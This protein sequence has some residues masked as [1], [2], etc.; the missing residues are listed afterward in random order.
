MNR[1]YGLGN[2][3][4]D[5]CQARGNF[6]R[7]ATNSSVGDLSMRLFIQLKAN[8]SRSIFKMVWWY[9]SRLVANFAEFSPLPALIQAHYIY[10]PGLSGPIRSRGVPRRRELY[11]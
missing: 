11:H 4:S 3:L 8:T 5:L 6:C 9:R 1:D 2:K 10:A 7:E